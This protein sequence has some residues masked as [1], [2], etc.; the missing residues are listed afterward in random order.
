MAED[1]QRPGIRRRGQEAA[2]SPGAH[3]GISVV[4]H[5]G[6]QQSPLMRT[7][8]LVIRSVRLVLGGTE[9]ENTAGETFPAM[10]SGKER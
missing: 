5:S 3:D 7:V 9:T 2:V 4:G 10:R 8:H 1:K 6:E